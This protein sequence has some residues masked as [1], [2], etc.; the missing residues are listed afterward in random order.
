VDPT[1]SLSYGPIYRISLAARVVN[2]IDSYPQTTSI[3]KVEAVG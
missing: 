3:I 1:V 2:P